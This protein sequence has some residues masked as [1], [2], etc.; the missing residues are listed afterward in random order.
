ML[1]KTAVEHFKTR[2]ALA[3]A[4]GLTK[5]AIS[6][7]GEVVPE[8]RAYQLE[9]LTKRALRVDRQLY[10]RNTGRQRSGISAHSN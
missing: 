1:T 2:V 9:L 10:G 3:K 7:W 8:G 4:L 6:N 5:G